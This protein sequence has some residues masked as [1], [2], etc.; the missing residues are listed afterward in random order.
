MPRSAP[1]TAGIDL[2]VDD[3]SPAVSW[4]EVRNATLR[5]RGD[6]VLPPGSYGDIDAEQGTL[7]LGVADSTQPVRYTMRA[8]TT[9]AKVQLRLLGPVIVTLNANSSIG[10]AGNAANPEWLDVRLAN[11]SLSIGAGAQVHGFILAAEGAVQI[12]VGAQVTGSVAGVDVTL[13]TKAR[14]S[15]PGQKLMPS[16]QQ[17]FLP[18]ALRVQA[19]IPAINQR[20]RHDYYASVGYPG[21]VPHVFLVEGKRAG[22]ARIDQQNDRLALLAALTDALV[23]TGFDQ[24]VVTVVRYRP[25]GAQGEDVTNFPFTRGELDTALRFAGRKNN[26]P[27]NIRKISES[28][29]LLNIFAHYCQQLAAAKQPAGR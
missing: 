26:A 17:P 11:G 18:K 14:V 23:D 29:L 22:N 20:Y 12:G 10:D 5:K 25:G 6:V 13:A 8:L 24:A 15:K 3:R 9:G 7:V 2:I 27:D 4:G 28:P 1:T 19:R 21:D 16:T